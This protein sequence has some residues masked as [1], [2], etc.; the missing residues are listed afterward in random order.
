M[1]TA[2]MA[3]S[4]EGLQLGTAEYIM[5][6]KRPVVQEGNRGRTST[7][8][9]VLPCKDARQLKTRSHREGEG[10]KRLQHY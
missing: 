1:I 3:A 5:L 2:H 8:S 10:K 7:T 9:A 4:K 6:I